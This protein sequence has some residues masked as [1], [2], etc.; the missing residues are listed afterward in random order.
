MLSAGIEGG[1]NRRL[2]SPVKPV[3]RNKQGCYWRSLMHRSCGPWS[4]LVKSH[5][6]S[7]ARKEWP[8]SP[9]AQRADGV[10]T[11]SIGRGACVPLWS[12]GPVAAAR[13]CCQRP[14]ALWSLGAGA[15]A[16]CC[17]EMSVAA[18]WAV[19]PRVALHGQD[20]AFR[21]A[22]RLSAWSKKLASEAG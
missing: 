18:L 2:S 14:C 10:L 19:W 1:C 16:G 3:S 12:L 15:A 11:S 21:V 4:W 9:D 5:V 13:C 20:V 17:C 22:S 6:T 8:F 7:K